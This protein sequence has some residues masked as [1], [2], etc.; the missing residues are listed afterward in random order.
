MATL[1]SATVNGARLT[2]TRAMLWDAPLLKMTR[3]RPGRSVE[4][5]KIEESAAATA[6]ED[7]MVP[8]AFA[9]RDDRRKKKSKK[10]KRQAAKRARVEEAPLEGWTAI[11]NHEDPAW[12]EYWKQCNDYL[13]YL[14]YSQQSQPSTKATETAP[15]TVAPLD[16]AAD[17]QTE[18]A[19]DPTG[20]AWKEY[21]EQQYTSIFETYWRGKYDESLKTEPASAEQPE[22]DC[23]PASAADSAEIDMRSVYEKFGLNASSDKGYAIRALSWKDTHSC[24]VY[25]RFTKA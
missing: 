6:D 8:A 4:S 24:L 14:Y 5:G 23:P 10:A 13:V 21:F 3:R 18:A 2:L 17:E 7:E 9:G 20:S 15:V 11:A 12:L 25:L 22:R 19:S 16:V 1:A